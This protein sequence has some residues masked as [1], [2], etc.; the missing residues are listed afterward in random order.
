MKKKLYIFIFLVCFI[1]TFIYNKKIILSS[2]IG[3]LTLKII[4]DYKNYKL[5]KNG[6]WD[7]NN[8]IFKKDQEINKKQSTI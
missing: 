4:N 3:L 5:I 7:E 6:I 1:N 8:K 2:I